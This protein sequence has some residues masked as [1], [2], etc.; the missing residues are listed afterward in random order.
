MIKSCATCIWYIDSYCYRYPP[1]VCVVQTDN[2]IDYWNERPQVE[3]NDICGEYD[4]LFVKKDSGIK[5]DDIK[6]K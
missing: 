3:K 5:P 1:T 2:G 6:G 4:G